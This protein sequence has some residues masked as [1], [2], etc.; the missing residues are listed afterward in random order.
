MLG[1]ELKRNPK[2]AILG[3]SYDLNERAPPT[4]NKTTKPSGSFVER[5]VRH[6]KHLGDIETKQF[7]RGC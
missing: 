3:Y 7:V 6:K 5:V 1:E 4:I 2:E